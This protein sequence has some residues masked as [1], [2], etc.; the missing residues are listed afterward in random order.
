MLGCELPE[1]S[2]M[3]E[4]IDEL[5]SIVVYSNAS[6]PAAD[7]DELVLDDVISLTRARLGTSDEFW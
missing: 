3:I 2:E 1:A 7:T 5:E 4:D 6:D